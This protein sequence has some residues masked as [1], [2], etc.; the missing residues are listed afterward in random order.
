MQLNSP[1]HY[2]VGII[3]KQGESSWSDLASDANILRYR[4]TTYK[5]RIALHTYGY[6]THA[7]H[8]VESSTKTDELMNTTITNET[9]TSFRAL[10]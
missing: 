7:G 5:D 10:R 1:Y 9:T 6:V 2:Q 4:H 8:D 3:H